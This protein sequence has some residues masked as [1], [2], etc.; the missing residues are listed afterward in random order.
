VK[1]FAHD[2]PFWRRM[3]AMGARSF[4]RWWMR[5]SPPLFGLA[6]AAMM[7]GARR[8][9]RENLERIR[10]PAPR[11]RE[12]LETAETFTTY[13]SC[14][15]E[16][17]AQG[18][19]NEE[20]LKTTFVGGEHMTLAAARNRGVIILTMH[21][22]GWEVVTPLFAR[23]T[24]LDMMIVME[25]ERSASAEAI[26]DHARSGW[27]AKFVRVG[28]DPL[29]ALPILRHLEKKGAVAMQIDRPPPSG[30]TLAVKL[31]GR[32]YAIPEGPLRIAQLSGALLLPQFSARLGFHEYYVKSY[33]PLEL[34][35]RPSPEEVLDVAQKIADAMGESLRRFPTQWFHFAPA[36]PSQ[37]PRSS[38]TRTSPGSSPG[39]T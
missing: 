30:R 16:T 35:R 12:T 6:A 33:P 36:E 23:D 18:S 39:S 9:V 19:K 1:R 34:P 5:Y 2:G 24:K 25:R 8:V 15:S 7:P 3:A 31:L 29:S 32:P 28:D 27:G 22:A 13:A 21:T 17:L 20:P 10:G 37:S 14:L 11:W 38:H 26:Q 4:P